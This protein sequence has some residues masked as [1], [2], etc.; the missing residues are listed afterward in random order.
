MDGSEW[1]NERV[2]DTLHGHFFTADPWSLQPS[3]PVLIVS[4]PP[5]SENPLH[6]GAAIYPGQPG[7]LLLP[8]SMPTS[9]KPPCL[10]SPHLCFH[11]LHLHPPRSL[12]DCQKTFSTHTN[13]FVCNH[14][15]DWHTW[16]VCIHG[17]PD[18]WVNLWMV[19][20]IGVKNIQSGLSF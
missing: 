12:R 9:M 19:S 5:N 17:S 20:S 6:G 3:P 11:S 16:R 8:F 10:P 2:Q 18:I 14:L 13:R 15:P 7:L 4:F 1:S